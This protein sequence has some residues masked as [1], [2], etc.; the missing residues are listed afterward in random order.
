MFFKKKERNENENLTSSFS[1]G[2][3]AMKQ[4]PRSRAAV[5]RKERE[6]K[7]TKKK[8]QRLAVFMERKS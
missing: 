8:L 3:C 7:F 4:Q 5:E 2:F 1:S 6:K